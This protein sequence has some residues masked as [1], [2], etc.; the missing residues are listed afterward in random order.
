ML[1]HISFP[2]VITILIGVILFF[3][4]R[5]NI[6]WMPFYILGHELTHAFFVL[7]F[8]GE[9]FKIMVKKDYGYTKTDKNNIIIRLGPYFLP[10]WIIFILIIF[11]IIKIF[12]ISREGIVVI[13]FNYAFYIVYSLL[14]AI[15]I[16]YNLYL[17]KRNPQDLRES[18]VFLSVTFTINLFILFMNLSLY[19][20]LQSDRIINSFL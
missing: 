14:Y 1:A 18:G 15:F 8:S 16:Y 5:Y 20:F 11:Y 13:Y 10:L 9:V 2:F 4:T 6:N 12:I 7:L 3:L 19:L 17:L